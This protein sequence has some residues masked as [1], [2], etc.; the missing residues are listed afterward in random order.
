MLPKY[1]CYYNECYNKE[2]NLYRQYFRIEGHPK[3]DKDISSSKS[4]KISIHDKLIE[5]KQYLKNIEENKECVKEKK[6][7]PVGI[8][9]KKKDDEESFFILDYRI[10]NNRYN[11]KMKVNKS[12]SYDENYDLFKKKVLNKYPN[13]EV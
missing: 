10:D 11:L 1:V 6:E 2:K 12:K 4:N 3:L 13:Y 7:L 5:I 8:R 9:L